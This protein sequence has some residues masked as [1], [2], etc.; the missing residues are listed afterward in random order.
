MTYDNGE[1]GYL[2]IR[3]RLAKKRAKSTQTEAVEP[4]EELGHIV[5]LLYLAPTPNVTESPQS[6]HSSRRHGHVH[7]QR[8]KSARKMKT[9]D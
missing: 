2:S 5:K 6:P 1:R 7:L 9:M 4:T 3:L 8:G